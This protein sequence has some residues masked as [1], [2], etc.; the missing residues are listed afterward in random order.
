MS[1]LI[2]RSSLINEL[3]TENQKCI[4]TSTNSLF[5]GKGCG[6]VGRT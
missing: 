4:T 3:L 5:S 6:R 1:D 2:S